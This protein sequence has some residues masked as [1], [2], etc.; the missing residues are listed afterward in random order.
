MSESITISTKDYRSDI[1][2]NLHMTLGGVTVNVPQHD[3]LLRFFTENNA[4]HYDCGRIKGELLHCATDDEDSTLLTCYIKNHGL[5]CGMLQCTYIDMSP[6]DG[7]ED[8][9]QRT[10]S[11]NNINLELVDDISDDT[12]AIDGT[13]VADI[14]SALTL[15]E[16]SRLLNIASISYF[17]STADDGYN[18]ATVTQNDGTEHQWQIKNG[19]KGEMGPQGLKGEQGDQGVGFA[20]ASSPATADG[21]WHITLTNGDTVTID[22]NHVHPQYETVSPITNAASG[23]LTVNEYRDFGSVSALTVTLTGGTMANYD[24][25]KFAFTCA[26]DSTTLTLPSGVKL[27][28]DMEMEMAAGRRFECIIDYANCLT[29][30]CWD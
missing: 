26:S 6:N 30:N 28:V 14:V 13:I 1:V 9:V 20:S 15:M 23:A 11:V 7:M 21:T 29:F 2:L 12:Q 3:F 25:Y 24:L 8:G 17:Q 19:S 5:G 16:S 4:R 22:L 10:F 27:P 18:V